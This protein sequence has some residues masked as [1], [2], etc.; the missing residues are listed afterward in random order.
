M[1]GRDGPGPIASVVLGSEQAAVAAA[2]AL[3]RRGVWVHPIRPPTVPP[4]TSRLRITL[5]S[6]HH[7]TEI[8]RLAAALVAEGI[9]LT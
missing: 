5:S 6:S 4:G 7:P 9:A 1:T 2:E 3:L 8:E